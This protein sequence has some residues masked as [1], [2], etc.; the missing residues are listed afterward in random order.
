MQL[1]RLTQRSNNVIRKRSNDQHQGFALQ[2]P[3]S[4][5]AAAMYVTR[6]NKAVRS[7]T[8]SFTTTLAHGSLEHI[9]KT[10]YALR[11]HFGHLTSVT[12][13]SDT[14]Q[15]CGPW[16]PVC[17]PRKVHMFAKKVSI[18]YKYETKRYRGWREIIYASLAIKTY[19]LLCLQISEKKE[20]DMKLAT[21]NLLVRSP[22]SKHCTHHA[23]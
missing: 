1:L 22:L 6:I 9:A 23:R 2:S 18:D 16:E 5:T 10:C 17:F 14:C 4:T 7:T 12:A 21:P 3:Y 8:P 15:S 20:L 11:C 13:I 19:S